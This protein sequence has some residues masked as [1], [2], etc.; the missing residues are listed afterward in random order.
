MPEKVNHEHGSSGSQATVQQFI[1]AENWQ[2]SW[3]HL[4][5]SKT[6][7]ELQTAWSILVAVKP[8]LAQNGLRLGT[9]YNTALKP[10]SGLVPLSI[11]SHP[12]IKGIEIWVVS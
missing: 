1:M 6:P 2:L 4:Q 5:N 12:T 8:L 7:K 9:Y 11:V 10:E 3:T